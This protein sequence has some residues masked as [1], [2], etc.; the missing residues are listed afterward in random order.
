MKLINSSV[1]EEGKA[2]VIEVKDVTAYSSYQLEKQVANKSSCGANQISH[3]F[4]I[5]IPSTVGIATRL[6]LMNGIWA[7]PN[8]LECES[9]QFYK[10]RLQVSAQCM[11]YKILGKQ[12]T[13]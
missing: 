7:E 9:H 12:L 5:K 10:L 1:Q 3:A 13:T 8:I 4:V 6:C 2:E 11:W